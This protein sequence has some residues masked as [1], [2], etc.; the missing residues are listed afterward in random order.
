MT[1]GVKDLALTRVA[2]THFFFGWTLILSLF[3]HDISIFRLHGSLR[4]PQV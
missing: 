3:R 2:D 1:L 4:G